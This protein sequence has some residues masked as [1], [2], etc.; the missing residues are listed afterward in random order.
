MVQRVHIITIIENSPGRMGLTNQHGLSLHIETSGSKILFDAGPSNAVSSNAKTLGV[1]LTDVDMAILSHGHYDHSGGFEAF[2]GENPLALLYVREGADGEHYAKRK[3]GWEYI[4][5]DQRLFERN[6]KRIIKIKEN[7]EMSPG[8]HILAAIPRIEPCPVG[9][10]LLFKKE[11]DDYVNDLFDH[12]LVLVIEEDDGI[13]IFSGCGHPGVLNMVHAA[14][15]QFQKQR[16]KAVIGGF[17]LMY[18]SSS[19]DFTQNSRDASV[20]ADRLVQLGC[21]R[22]IS[23]HCTGDQ[24]TAVFKEK[25]KDRHVALSTGSEL[26]L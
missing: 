12:E 24:A 21:E 7:T 3:D 18:G 22:I 6:S 16:I 19:E 15:Q 13:V 9:N 23:G 11:G 2:F 20:I 4:G 5:V 17:H 1:R 8:L 25:L 14:R 26:D 10:R